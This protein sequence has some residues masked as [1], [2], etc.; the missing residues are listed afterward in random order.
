MY[1]RREEEKRR[2]KKEKKEKESIDSEKHNNKTR[3]SPLE[4]EALGIIGE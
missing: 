1:E 3:M 2:K 4:K